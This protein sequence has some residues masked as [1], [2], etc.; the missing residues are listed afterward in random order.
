MNPAFTNV[1]PD[2]LPILEEL[3]RREPIFHNPE[4]GSTAAEFERSTTPDYWEV[5]AS[6]RRYSRDFILAWAKESLAHFVDAKYAGWQTTEFGL[7]RLGPDTY[8][9]TY[10]LDQAGRR[11]RRSTIWQSSENGWRILYHQGT[12]ISVEEDDTIPV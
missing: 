6:G 1:E 2:L 4:F 7:R 10:M 5:G 11:T 8:L 12:I 9:L 3:R